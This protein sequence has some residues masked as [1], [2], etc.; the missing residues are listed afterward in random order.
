MTVNEGTMVAN[1]A[2]D[3]EFVPSVYFLAITWN[4]IPTP[5]PP[6]PDLPLHPYTHVI[7]LT[8]TVPC[9]GMINLF[10][11]CKNLDSWAWD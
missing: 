11:N 7:E 6:P 4:G 5:P 3:R 10:Q 9:V 8:K 1:Y 2:C